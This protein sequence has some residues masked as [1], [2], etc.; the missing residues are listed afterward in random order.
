[1]C[2]YIVK[3]WCPDCDVLIEVTPNGA[4]PKTTNKRQ[5]LVLHPYKGELCE[6]SGKDV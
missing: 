2:E 6:G 1:M 5:R 3:A 4:D